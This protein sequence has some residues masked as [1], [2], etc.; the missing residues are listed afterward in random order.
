MV[1]NIVVNTRLNNELQKSR[2]SVSRP[3][4]LIASVN[5]NFIP[6][7]ITE[8]KSTTKAAESVVER[9][10]LQCTTKRLRAKATVG[11][12]YRVLDEEGNIWSILM[13]TDYSKNP[14]QVGI[15]SVKIGSKIYYP[16]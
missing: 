1:G 13:Q 10:K 11:K 9:L 14:E 15:L 7:E 12:R 3:C 2:K 16:C 6:E 4:I 8:Y 5:G